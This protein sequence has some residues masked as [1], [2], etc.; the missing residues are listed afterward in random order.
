MKRLI[1]LFNILSII[2]AI[3]LVPLAPFTFILIEGEGSIPGYF[4]ETLLKTLM[5]AYTF[6]VV[7]C[8]TFSIRSIKRNENLKALVLS[9]MPTLTTAAIVLTYL[10][11]GIH[12]R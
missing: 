2:P 12:L 3:I 6:V 10:F 1:S 11:G 9:I 4:H 7:L 5:V 8:I